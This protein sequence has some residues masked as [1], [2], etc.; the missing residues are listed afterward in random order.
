MGDRIAKLIGAIGT[1]Q[2]IKAL[3]LS[4]TFEQRMVVAIIKLLLQAKNLEELD[5]SNNQLGG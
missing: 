3:S 4:N 5:V 1:S 2:N